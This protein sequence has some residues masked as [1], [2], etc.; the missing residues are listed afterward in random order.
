MTKN[1]Y[2]PKITILLQFGDKIL[3]MLFIG[4]E[5]RIGKNCARTQDQGHSFFAY[6][7]T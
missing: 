7:P 1:A 6:G 3:A 4:Q 2:L 5:V